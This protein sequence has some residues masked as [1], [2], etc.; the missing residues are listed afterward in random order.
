MFANANHVIIE[1]FL[2]Q[3]KDYGPSPKKA[4][5]SIFRMANQHYM[6]I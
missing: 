3:N 2:G 1:R 5:E 4:G 6:E